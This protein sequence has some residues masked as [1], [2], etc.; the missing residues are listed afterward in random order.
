MEKFSTQTQETTTQGEGCLPCKAKQR[1]LSVLVSVDQFRNNTKEW[2]TSAISHIQTI[3]KETTD[4]TDLQI[5]TL[6]KSL[7]VTPSS[8]QL[9]YAG[10][11]SVAVQIYNQLLNSG[12]VPKISGGIN[13]F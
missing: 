10:P 9:L 12:I 2:S 6:I 7:Q 11:E 8:E 4:F 1:K 5:G 3:L 13:K